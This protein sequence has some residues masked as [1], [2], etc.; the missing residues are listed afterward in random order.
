MPM[1][2]TLVRACVFATGGVTLALELIASRILTPYVGGSLYVWTAILTITLLALATGYYLGGR[3]SARAS[4]AAF[5]PRIPAVAA[6]ILCAVAWLY[7]PVLPALAHGNVLLGA[8]LGSLAVLGPALVLLSAMGPLGIALTARAEGDSGAGT[9]FAVGTVGS[10]TGA[11]V[12]A[13]LLLPFLSPPA[14]LLVLALLLILVAGAALMVARDGMTQRGLLPAAVLAMIV[15]GLAIARGPERADLG[16]V[17]ARH[18]ETIRG[19]HA[20]A[21]VVELRHEHRP[22]TVRLYLEENQMQS[23][24]SPDLPGQPLHY[25]SIVQALLRAV[26]PRDGR[27]LVLG[28]AGGTI[29]SDLAAAGRAVTAVDINPQAAEVAERWFGLDPARVPVV[30]A[31]ARRFVSRCAEGPYDAI[32]FDTFSGLAPPDHLITRE[33]FAAAR[34]CLAPDGALIVNAIVP[35]SG[36]PVT[37]RLLAAIGQGA[38]RPVAIYEDPSRPSPVRNRIVLATAR[39]APVLRIADYPES[40]FRRG[41]V[42]LHAKRLPADALAEVAPL[43]DSSN[44]FVLRMADSATRMSFV[45]VPATWQ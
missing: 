26:V 45:P 34:G 30:V 32:L 43:S 41:P 12:A 23:A 7:P 27:I 33:A 18:L 20:A 35:D 4:R 15:V 13:F 1:R 29:A 21:V 2:P 9:M 40:L 25:A 31:D 3:W 38:E 28:L 42:T 5:F 36:H 14:T 10:V 8:F 44:D 17:T 16:E 11:L 24:S 22:G 6:V 37:R 19:P 39:P